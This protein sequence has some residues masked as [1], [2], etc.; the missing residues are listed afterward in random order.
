MPLSLGR[1]EGRLGEARWSGRGLFQAHPHEEA[2]ISGG[3]VLEEVGRAGREGEVAD[4]FVDE[5]EVGAIKGGNQG[6]QSGA[7]VGFVDGKVG[8]IRQVGGGM[9]RGLESEKVAEALGVCLLAREQGS[10]YLVVHFAWSFLVPIRQKS[11]L[12][13]ASRTRQG[14]DKLRANVDL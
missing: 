1:G 8:F 13:F 6:G 4:D 12:A 10:I 11:T 9:E 5:D 2:V 14:R 3:D 7:E